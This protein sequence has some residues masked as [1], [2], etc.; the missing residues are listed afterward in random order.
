MESPPPVY[1]KSIETKKD[2]VLKSREYKDIPQL[3]ID[4]GS[5]YCEHVDC[6]LMVDMRVVD[7]K[8]LQYCR[9]HLPKTSRN[10][11]CLSKGC[12]AK[13]T[14]G[15][16]TQMTPESELVFMYCLDHCRDTNCLVE[17]LDLFTRLDGVF[18]PKMG[19]K[20]ILEFEK[21]NK[22]NNSRVGKCDIKAFSLIN[23]RHH[24]RRCGKSYCEKCCNTF[25]KL[26]GFASQE[27]LRVCKECNLENVKEYN[28]EKEAVYSSLSNESMGTSGFA[29]FA[30]GFAPFVSKPTSSTALSPEG[31][32]N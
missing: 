7:T 22:C 15:Y 5:C 13:R 24:C 23:R 9:N 10:D 18:E 32:K 19:T 26:V 6:E 11:T 16:G 12:T 14:H 28:D 25:V 31:N 27:I 29:P 3:I 4:I 21:D 2:N 30:S 17:N 20:E 1:T 8:Q